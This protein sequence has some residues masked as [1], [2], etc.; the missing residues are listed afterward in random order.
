MACTYCYQHHKTKNK[1]NFETAKSIID[2]IL[3]ADEK[4]NS[5]ITSTYC[6]GAIIEFIG[7]EPWLEIDLITKISDYFMSELFRRQHPWAIKFKFSICSNGLLHFE[8][9]V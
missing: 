1:M 7:G 8:P 6:N 2:M 9:K 5:Y 3:D 4:T